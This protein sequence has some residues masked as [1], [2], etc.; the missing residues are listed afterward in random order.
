M[1][2]S[3]PQ[4]L[5]FIHIPR[6]AGTSLSALLTNNKIFFNSFTG[7]A[8]NP[9]EEKQCWENQYTAETII[10]VIGKEKW[11]SYYKFT[12]VRNPWDRMVSHYEYHKKRLKNEVFQQQN[13]EV[14]SLFQD[15]PDFVRLFRLCISPSTNLM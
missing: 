7:Y 14:V 12:V 5:I 13:P 6:C 3:D 8:A 9:L 2:V 15:S 10:K 11:S 1:P 4:K